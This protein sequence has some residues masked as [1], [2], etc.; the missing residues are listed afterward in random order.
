MISPYQIQPVKS[1]VTIFAA[2]KICLLAIALAS[3]LCHDYDTSTSVFFES[4]YGANAS[5][6]LLATRLTRWDAFYF[7]HAARDGYVYEQEWAFGTGV[8][9]SIRYICNAIRA[10]G[11]TVE[12][13]LEPLVGIV[14]AHISHLIAALALYKLTVVISKSQKLAFISSVLSIVSPAGIFLSSPY[15]ESPCSAL[16]FLGVYFFALN[17]ENANNLVKRN[18]SLVFS[19]GLFGAATLM[20][21]NGLSYGL[22]FAI[23]AVRRG[24][25][26]LS[27]PNVNDLITLAGTVVGGLLLAAGSIVPQAMAWMTYCNVKVEDSRP[28]CHSTIPS[29]YSYV[30]A[31]YWYVF[32]Y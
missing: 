3:S 11:F 31:E 9:L 8:S 21:S 4:L 2:W 5:T 6:P 20:R 18:V 22:L 1:I 30:Q 24:L 16:A 7:V 15:G 32:S 10:S 29:I 19:G 25:S 27:Q 14:I 17:Y 13:G 23:E 28:W 26:F 12:A